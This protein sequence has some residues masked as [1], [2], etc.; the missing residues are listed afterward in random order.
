MTF[1]L[2]YW[3]VLLVLLISVGVSA[4]NDKNPLQ[5]IGNPPVIDLFSA[6]AA[7]VSFGNAVTLRWEVADPKALVRIDPAPGN[8]AVV[9]S[10]NVPLMTSTTFTLTARNDHGQTQRLLTV[11]V[12]GGS[13][14]F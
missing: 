6:S 7:T 4:C 11:L 10:A 2:R 8:V 9:G 14:F 5:P 13:S 3:L 12:I 1:N